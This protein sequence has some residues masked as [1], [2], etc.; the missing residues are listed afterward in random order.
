[1]P[2]KTLAVCTVASPAATNTCEFGNKT[3]AGTAVAVAEAREIAK[4]A[5]EEAERAGVLVCDGARRGKMVRDKLGRM[6][7]GAGELENGMSPGAVT[8]LVSASWE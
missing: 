5:V 2:D 7:T 6:S 3:A 1:V 4:K 8:Q